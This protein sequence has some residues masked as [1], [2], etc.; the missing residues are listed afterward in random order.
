[1]LILFL[2]VSKGF[3]KDLA[4]SS[5]NILFIRTDGQIGFNGQRGTQIS[6]LPEHLTNGTHTFVDIA[7][8]QEYGL[9]LDS[10]GKLHAWGAKDKNGL[11]TVPEELQSMK[12]TSISGG[13]FNFTAIDV[14]GQA[15]TWGSNKFNQATLPKKLVG[16]TVERIDSGYYQNYALTEDGDVVAWA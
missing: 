13:R 8:G 16:E 5:S 15:H 4:T 2:Q 7:A 14:D 1:M 10:E 11:A 3:I 12:F 9:A 6:T